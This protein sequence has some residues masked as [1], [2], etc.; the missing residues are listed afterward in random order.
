PVE[1]ALAQRA[2]GPVAQK[3]WS[4][5]TVEDFAKSAV[6]DPDLDIGLLSINGLQSTDLMCVT[7]RK[8]Q[9]TLLYI[10]GNSSPIHRFDNPAQMKT[11][12]AKQAADPVKR[13]S[14]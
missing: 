7:D 8:T 2:L 10:P 6:K 14:L 1:T 3:D 4:E 5:L 13:E 9:L 12:L 11:W